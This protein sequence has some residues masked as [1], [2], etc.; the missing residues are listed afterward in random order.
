MIIQPKNAR[1]RAGAAMVAAVLSLAA[2]GGGGGGTQA[3]T[4]PATAPT[5]QAPAITVQPGPQSRAARGSA[6]FTVTASGADLAY[7]WQRDGKDIAGATAA[8]T[9]WPAS[10]P[11]TRAPPSRSS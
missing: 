7:Q 11:A 1:L 4:P 6:T 10:S 3:G 9:R 2:C 8:T 5:V